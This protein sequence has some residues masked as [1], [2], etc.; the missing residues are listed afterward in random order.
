M[1]FTVL[2][3]LVS[4]SSPGDKFDTI[5]L[6]RSDLRTQTEETTSDIRYCTGRLRG[7]GYLRPSIRRLNWKLVR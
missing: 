5:L 2:M 1:F 7:D 3:R 4:G 6:I